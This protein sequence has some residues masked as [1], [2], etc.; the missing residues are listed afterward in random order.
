MAR[1]WAVLTIVQ[2][3]CASALVTELT[4]EITSE[5]LLFGGIA[6][7]EAGLGPAAARFEIG[8]CTNGVSRP[9]G[10]ALTRREFDVLHRVALGESNREIAD[11]LF[12]SVSTV[13]RHLTTI[14]G[15]LGASSR[16]EA[17]LLARSLGLSAASES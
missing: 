9:P 8:T 11:S 2:R 7:V 16:H 3:L 14:F 5:A 13:K 12:I 1:Q 10:T 17:V 4:R 6:V 15:K